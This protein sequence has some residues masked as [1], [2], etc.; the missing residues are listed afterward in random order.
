MGYFPG[1]QPGG[2]D[3][4]SS[5]WS[6]DGRGDGAFT[7][8]ILSVTLPA[9]TA[10][11]R[12]KVYG[13][14]ADTNAGTDRIALVHTEAILDC[15]D[16]SLVLVGAGPRQNLSP[17][18]EYADTRSITLLGNTP[19]VL[20]DMPYTLIRITTYTGPGNLLVV[21]ATL[22]EA[23]VNDARSSVNMQVFRKTA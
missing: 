9:D 14:L 7:G 18:A 3:G 21:H 6:Y 8:N 19:A 1:T 10:F 2:G 20:I 12:F 16:H 13:I 11:A 22:S 15:S 5:F 23:A 17:P 4:F